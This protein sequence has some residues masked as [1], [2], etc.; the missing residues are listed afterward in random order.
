MNQSGGRGRGRGRGGGRQSWRQVTADS[1]PEFQTPVGNDATSNERMAGSLDRKSHSSW[2]VR[3]HN[4]DSVVSRNNLNATHAGNHD[5]QQDS[6][7]FTGAN[8]LDRKP[9]S[10]WQVKG[11]SLDGVV[12]RINENATPTGWQGQQQDNPSFSGESYFRG[13]GAKQW[14]ASSKASN[15]A[16]SSC[17]EQ[18]GF[19]SVEARVPINLD[20]SFMESVDNLADVSRLSLESAVENSHPNSGAEVLRSTEKE[21]D[22]KNNE[23]SECS[24]ALET[25]DICPPKSDSLIT[26]NPSLLAKNREKRNEMKNSIAGPKGIILRSGM[27]LLKG[28]ISSSEQAKILK[29]CRNHGMGPAGFY[30]P[31]FREGGKLHLKMMCFGEFWD[32]E[33]SKYLEVR[34]MDLA[35]PPLIPQDFML[36]VDRAIKDSHS[37]IA[38]HAGVKNVEDILPPVKP[39]I[40]LVNYYATTGRLGLHQDKDEGRKSLDKGIPIVSFSIGDSAEFL[41]GDQV[42]VEMA[43]KVILES[44]DV[45]IFGGKSRH[46]FHGVSAILPRTAPVSLLQE[47]NFLSGRLNLTFR[48]HF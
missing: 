36:L 28:Y 2:K 8:S 32:P 29:I 7:T 46:I 38:E 37:L 23:Y 14:R 33:T 31:R 44:G 13:R 34:P 16:D 19:S 41:Y 30:Q 25:F 4:S 21:H 35:K 47:T 11:H 39:D 18:A 26:L 12:S 6:S 45:L 24:T 17:D 3:G 40:C 42:D 1:S 15:T 20:R 48:Q 9:H 10:S 22:H 5:Q 27:V 43:N